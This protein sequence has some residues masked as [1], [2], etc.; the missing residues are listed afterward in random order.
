MYTFSTTPI[1]AMVEVRQKSDQIDCGL[2]P[3]RIIDT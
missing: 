2:K 3:K 1:A